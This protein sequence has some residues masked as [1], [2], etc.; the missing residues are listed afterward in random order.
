M[1]MELVSREPKWI[2]LWGSVH[3]STR[4]FLS[5]LPVAGMAAFFS[6]LCALGMAGVMT[7]IITAAVRTV[8]VC[9]ATNPGALASTHPAHLS[10]LAAAW[11]K[12]HPVVWASSGY[13][14]TFPAPSAPG[15]G[16]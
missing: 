15:H 2:Q 3:D 12:F 16:V 9:F 13:A 14:Q 7:S 11:A 4:S 1:R 10:K 6:F 8:F 5:P